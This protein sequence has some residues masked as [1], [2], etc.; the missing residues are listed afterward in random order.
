MNSSR[1]F[2][3][4]PDSRLV[5]SVVEPKV[6]RMDANLGYQ[7]VV[8]DMDRVIVKYCSRYCCGCLHY[9]VLF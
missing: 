6:E 1:F 4:D 3:I 7:N 8:Y 5:V 9:Q 2:H